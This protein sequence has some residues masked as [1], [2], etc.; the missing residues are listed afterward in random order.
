MAVRAD[1]R[2]ALH[3][4]PDAI[5]AHTRFH[6]WPDTGRERKRPPVFRIRARILTRIA[7]RV[8]TGSSP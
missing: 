3:A 7:R 6:W 8:R 5:R 4:R 2:R 1:C